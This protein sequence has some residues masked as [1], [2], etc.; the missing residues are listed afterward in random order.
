MGSLCSLDRVG[1]FTA[2]RLGHAIA[3]LV[4]DGMEGAG[5]MTLSDK[6]A[7]V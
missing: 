5:K 3:Q 7:I 2:S 6:G 4:P 1:D